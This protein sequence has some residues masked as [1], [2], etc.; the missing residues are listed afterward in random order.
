MY[1]GTQHARI[2]LFADVLKQNCC[3]GMSWLIRKNA[4][5]AEGLYLHD[6]RTALVQ[7]FDF[8]ISGIICYLQN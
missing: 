1:F 8:L 4:L 3:N 2:Y 6:V 5:L 7:F